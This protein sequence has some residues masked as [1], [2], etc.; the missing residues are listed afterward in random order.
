[1]ASLK[2]IFVG[3]YPISP[4][5]VE[6]IWDNG[7]IVFDTNVLL[8][9]YR[10]SKKTQNVLFQILDRY[11]D[12][13]WL[14][15]HVGKEFFKNRVTV[16]QDQEKTFSEFKK[17][18]L[19]DKKI[20]ELKG[21]KDKHIAIDIA[22]INE[23]LNDANEKI[24]NKLGLFEAEII[25]YFKND[26]ILPRLN[27][28]VGEKIGEPYTEAELREL[29][30]IAKERYDNGIPPGYADEDKKDNQY[31][32]CIIWLQ[33][34]KH[35]AEVKKPLVFITRDTKEDWFQLRSKKTI[36]PRPELL[37]EVYNKTTQKCLIYSLGLFLNKA[38]KELG[39]T[40]SIPEA[41]KEIDTINATVELDN[42]ERAL[43]EYGS[44]IE[45][46][47]RIV[48][49]F[50]Q[51]GKHSFTTMDVVR[52]ITGGKYRIGER[53]NQVVAW[54]LNELETD[55]FEIH[56]SRR[57]QTEKDD[58]NKSTSLT[59][60]EFN[61]NAHNSVDFCGDSDGKGNLYCYNCKSYRQFF[62]GRCSQCGAYNED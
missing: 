16:I 24:K 62:G 53:I 52:A 46:I 45:D 18:V 50:K 12:R 33:I 22:E 8:N 47:C 26:F 11:Q 4:E 21:Y 14:P 30:K 58:N 29:T 27:Q 61:E 3:H 28:I 37:E 9:L 49:S 36:G 32:D 51:S 35:I 44:T 57:L 48:Y 7:V 39:I 41:I 19:L 54:I 55:L 6:S 40:D 20:E 13:I 56:N 25:D 17:T 42:I 59:V 2:D 15:F 31:G 38:S 23:I 5:D 10:C 43:L 34:I 1:M 60:W